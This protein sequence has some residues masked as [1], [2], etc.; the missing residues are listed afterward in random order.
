M[1]KEQLEVLLKA[2]TLMEE[3]VIA[4]I[5]FLKHEDNDYAVDNLYK[6]FVIAKNSGNKKVRR[7]V[8]RRLDDYENALKCIDSK[9]LILLANGYEC[10]CNEEY[11]EAIKIYYQYKDLNLVDAKLDY[12]FDRLMFDI[13]YDNH[14][15]A[16]YESFVT[17]IINNPYLYEIDAYS[18]VHFFF[19]CGIVTCRDNMYS[20]L[21][22]TIEGIEQVI[23]SKRNTEYPQRAELALALLKILKNI[24]N[25]NTQ[26]DKQNVINEYK[27]VSEEHIDFEG[28]LNENMDAHILILK[29]ILRYGEREFASERLKKLLEVSYNIRARIEILKLLIEC[30]KGSNQEKYLLSIE[31]LNTLLL[32]YIARFQDVVNDGLFNTIRFYDFERDMAEIQELYE[33]DSLTGAF[34][35][36]VFYKKTHEIFSIRNRGTL[37]FFDLDKLKETN[38]QYSHSV[39]DEYLKVFSKGIMKFIDD[40][41]MLFRFGGDEF[42]LV[43]SKTDILEVENLLK[44]IIKYFSKY[45]TI[46]GKKVKIKFSAGVSLY[47][48]D[49]TTIEK[50]LNCSDKAMYEAKRNGGG[51]RIYSELHNDWKKS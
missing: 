13:L 8:L 22:R 46:L 32:K 30:Y 37:I 42:I 16:K 47:P 35:R 49:G 3:Q 18:T 45:T 29:Y 34:S 9:A 11:N 48:Y 21:L 31:E 7:I 2:K 33:N 14:I 26:E 40:T 10:I 20:G 27:K 50:V 41:Y 36:N 1:T 24:F 12:Y 23:N 6:L 5:E 39:G 44:K 15:A 51:Y 4:A 25:A 38:D 19:K 28:T 43:T 17:L